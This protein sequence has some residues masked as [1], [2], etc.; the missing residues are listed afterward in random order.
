MARATY[1]RVLPEPDAGDATSGGCH[2]VNIRE[3]LKALKLPHKLT[4]LC[5]PIAKNKKNKRSTAAFKTPYLYTRD[6]PMAAV[7]TIKQC[8]SKTVWNKKL[9]LVF[10]TQWLEHRQKKL[11]VMVRSIPSAAVHNFSTH[12]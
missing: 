3:L 6:C 2:Q 7:A 1:E 4:T 8:E 10:K 9:W 11:K 12:N 5:I